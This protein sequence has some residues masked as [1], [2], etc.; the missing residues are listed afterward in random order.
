MS[1][2]IKSLHWLDSYRSRL[3]AKLIPCYVV[4]KGDPD[5]GAMFIRIDDDTLYTPQY[6]FETD[7]RTWQVVAQGDAIDA[8]IAKQAKIDPD[9]WLLDVEN[10]G[11][12]LLFN[13]GL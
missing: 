4:K 11:E 2:R 9:Y 12:K 3:G 13:E 8:Y 7:Q 1:K 5:A 6:D 10:G